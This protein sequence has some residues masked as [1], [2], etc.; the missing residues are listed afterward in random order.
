MIMT[1]MVH[2]INLKKFLKFFFL[3]TLLNFNILYAETKKRP[4]IGIEFTDVTE[5]FIKLNNLDVKT[6]KNIIITGVV[7]TSAANEAN[8]IPGDVVISINNKITK[9]KQDLIEILKTKYAGDIVN[10]K[11]Y[12]KGNTL[13]K[14]VTLKTFPD[15]GFKSSWVKGSKLLKNTPQKNYGL[16]N[17]VLTGNDT[18]LY[19]KYFS[20]D[21]LSNTIMI[22]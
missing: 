17:I 10:L 22:I 19:P 16:E 14:N 12:R 7:E 1:K 11:I 13:T 18:I 20:K 4:W 21:L 2:G 3:I 9:V 15:P 8:I 5:E 6:P